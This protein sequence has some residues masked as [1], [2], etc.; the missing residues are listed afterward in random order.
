MK[1]VDV[2][3]LSQTIDNVSEALLFG[4]DIDRSEKDIIADFIIGRQGKPNSYADTFAPTESDMKRDYILF[5]G[6]K[7]KSGAGKCHMIGEEASRLL[8]KLGLNNDKINKALIRADNGLKKQI[9]KVYK[10]PG[11]EYGMYCCRSCSCALWI[12]LASGGLGNDTKMLKAG[13]NYLKKHRD[14]KGNWNGFPKYYTL[15]VL[16][17]MDINLALDELKYIAPLVERRLKK[18][19]TEE[20]KFEL[21]RNYMCEQIIEKVNSN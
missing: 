11:Y 2:N 20:D 7:I 5:T 18:K 10:N 9:D 13:L 17:E 1:Y 12:N 19:K 6:E 15:Y 3:S 16:N 8:R 14:S 21:R 4:F